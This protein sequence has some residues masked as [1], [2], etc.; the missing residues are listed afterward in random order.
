MKTKKGVIDMII[1]KVRYPCPNPELRLYKVTYKSEG[2]RVKGY[3]VEP[4]E[5]KIYSGL[6]YLR[7]GIRNVGKVRVPRIIQLASYGFVVFAPFY[8][9]ND[10]GEGW[11]DFAYLDRYD[12]MNGFSILKN[13][14]NVN[15]EAIHVFGF[16]RGGLMALLTAC[17]LPEV[18][19]VVTWGG[20]SDMFLAYE[21][22]IDLRRMLKR[23]IGGT[24]RKYPKRYEARTIFS[25]LPSLQ[26]SV[27][28]I[29]GEKDQNVGVEH[30]EK[31]QHALERL[32]KNVMYWKY[33]NEG[34][35]FPFHLQKE[36]T[37]KMLMWMK[38][39][40]RPSFIEDK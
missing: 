15:K 12:A 22:R 3:L 39:I 7:G 5:E 32:G 25:Y 4:K 19:S 18:C 21:E 26:A 20:V 9:G 1:E 27:L 31:L 23:V 6:L 34:H 37:E 2:L 29:H 13:H 33:E 10:G 16:S 35:I 24:P 14:K 38:G 30:A 36:V 17:Y 11:E 40:E 28:I 8:R